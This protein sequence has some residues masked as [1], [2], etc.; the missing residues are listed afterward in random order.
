MFGHGPESTADSKLIISWF[1]GSRDADAAWVFMQDLSNR[2]ANRVQLTTDGHRAYLDA[3]IG[4]FGT[5]IDYAMLVKIYGTAAEAE[6]RYS[7]PICVRAE[8]H[9]V[10]GRPNPDYMSYVERQNLTMHM[11]RFTRLTNASSKKFENHCHMVALYATW[12]NFCANSQNAQSNASY[13]SWR[14]ISDFGF[15]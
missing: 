11:R 9:E 6:K 10:I 2:L 7:P 5:G 4:A 8:R 1:I 13:R 12:Y 3:V 15:R 14:Y